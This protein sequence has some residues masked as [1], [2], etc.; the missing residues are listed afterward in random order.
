MNPT[1]ENSSLVLI[2]WLTFLMFTMFAMTTDAVGVI[3]PHIIEE[4]KLTLTQASAF[5]YAPMIAIAISG[6]AFGFLADR[7]GRKRTILLGLGLFAIACFLFSIG[8]TFESFVGLLALSGCAIGIFKTGALALI[9]DIST[10]SHD[11]TRTMNTVEGFFGVGAIIGPFIITYLLKIQVSWIYLYMFAGFMCM[12]MLLMAARVQYPPTQ[13]HEDH[14]KIDIRRTFHMMS[15]PYALGF[16]FVIALYVATEV[17]IYVWMPTLLKDY[18]GNF[19]WLATYALPIFFALR[20]GGRF[21]GSWI[22]IYFS[23][24]SVML[25]FSSCIFLCFLGTAIFGIDAAIFLLPISGLFMSMIYPTLNSKGISCF[26]KTEHGTIAGVILFFT[27]IA[28]AL[29]PI[30][31]GFVGDIFGHVRFGFYLATGFAG[32]LC[33]AMLFNWLKNPA[34]MRLTEQNKSGYSSAE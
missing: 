4:F 15:N 31:M 17:A 24:T 16:S 7:L 28:A 25:V 20:A 34:E 30:A 1:H 33:I 11:H 8:N 5:H 23:W 14:K 2:R 3:I 12:V 10:S 26:N 27:A 21:L 18:S 29:G 9:G 6:I 19:L 13:Q 32:L 22:L